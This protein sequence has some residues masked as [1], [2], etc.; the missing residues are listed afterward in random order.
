MELI[1]L[2]TKGVASAQGWPEPCITLASVPDGHMTQDRPR[3]HSPE[4]SGELL[5]KWLS[6]ANRPARL[7]AWSLVKNLLIGESGAD[8]DSVLRT[9]PLSWKEAEIEI[10]KISK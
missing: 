1:P 4:T 7:R 2:M 3:W 6:F 8:V 10:L 9:T 5:G